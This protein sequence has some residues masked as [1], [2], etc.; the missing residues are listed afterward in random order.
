MERSWARVSTHEAAL[1]AIRRRS[2]RCVPPARCESKRWGGSAQ[3][4]FRN[5]CQNLHGLGRGRVWN[6][7][8]T[9][10]TPQTPS[11]RRRRRRSSSAPAPPRTGR[12]RTRR[13]G[14]A[15]VSEQNTRREAPPVSVCGCPW[16]FAHHR[17]AQAHSCSP[18]R[19]ETRGRREGGFLAPFFHGAPLHSP[20]LQA[21]ALLLLRGGPVRA[22]TGGTLADR[23]GRGSR[24]LCARRS[25]F[26]PTPLGD[27][28]GRRPTAE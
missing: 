14:V 11:P 26:R 25:R 9:Q 28:C 7:P 2:S 20:V 19:Y 22:A 10:Q 27:S 3:A 1:V 12:M 5:P 4:A 18:P 23:G 21:A 8:A 15:S 17:C 16:G 6:Q 24:T 13:C